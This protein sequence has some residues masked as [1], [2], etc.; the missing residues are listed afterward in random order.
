VCKQMWISEHNS[1][2]TLV[3]QWS[4]SWAFLM[5]RLR[6]LWS[7][8]T[9]QS[10]NSPVQMSCVNSFFCSC[11]LSY[12]I[13]KELAERPYTNCGNIKIISAIRKIIRQS[14]VL[15]WEVMASLFPTP[16]TLFPSQSQVLH[17]WSNFQPLS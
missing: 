17:H 15:R 5:L 2:H 8:I 16:A 3:I 1:C 12:S 13:I 14:E 7:L 10:L 9:T 4:L 6:P 11:V